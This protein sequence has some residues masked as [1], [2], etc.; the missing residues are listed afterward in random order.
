MFE[1]I[2]YFDT[3]NE[4]IYHRKNCI[5]C[6]QPLIPIL[7]NFVGAH[8]GLKISDIN[9]KLT[10]DKFVFKVEYYSPSIT[11]NTECNINV[12][13]NEL[14]SENDEFTQ[15]LIIFDVM[16][17]HIDLQ[18]RN[19]KCK[20]NYY[21]SSTI[22]KISTGDIMY[23]ETVKINTLSVDMECFNLSKL[24]IKNDWINNTTQIFSTKNPN[25]IPCETQMIL[26]DTI[27]QDKL[28][29]KIKTI[30]NFS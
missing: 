28:F 25:S 14:S 22:L 7:T 2:V 6:K 8:R 13:N 29:N 5:F 12:L 20:Y 1:H 18:C 3:I 16:A 15:S 30:V 4:F 11:I 24:W 9:A 27:E 26:F 23:G 17:P 19:A 10:N 21:I